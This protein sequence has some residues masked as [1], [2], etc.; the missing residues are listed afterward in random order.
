MLG[1]ILKS[2]DEVLELLKGKVDAHP[3]ATLSH[4]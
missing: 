3:V 1:P 2:V 4:I